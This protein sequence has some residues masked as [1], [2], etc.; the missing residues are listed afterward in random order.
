MGQS[1]AKHCPRIYRRC[2]GCNTYKRKYKTFVHK[3]FTYCDKCVPDGYFAVVTNEENPLLFN[4]STT[5]V[6][7]RFF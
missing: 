4:T 6:W 5:K 1:C 2:D 3:Q 7:G